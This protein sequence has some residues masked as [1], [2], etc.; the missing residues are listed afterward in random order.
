[1]KRKLKAPNY[2]LLNYFVKKYKSTSEANFRDNLRDNYQKRF[3]QAIDVLVFSVR[4]YFDQPSFLVFEQLE[5]LLLIE[6]KGE[7]T[8][9]ELELMM[10]R[11]G[12]DKNVNYL[13]VELN[14][15]KDFLKDKNV[16]LFH[17][18]IKKKL[19]DTAERKLIVNICTICKILTVKLASS[20]AV[21]RPSSMARKV[22][23]WMQYIMLTARFNSVAILNSKKKRL[24]CFDVVVMANLLT[25]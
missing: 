25:E 4:D 23:T 19:I 17:D 2:T 13:T 10:K 22:K 11:Y 18:K 15:F 8:S 24:D 12:D 14:I 21:K 5:M 9:S 7:N 1:M 20:S 3:Y 6:L 16:E